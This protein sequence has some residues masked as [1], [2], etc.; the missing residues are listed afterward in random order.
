VNPPSTKQLNAWYCDQPRTGNATCT[1]CGK[2]GPVHYIQPQHPYYADGREGVFR[3]TDCLDKANVEARA[4]RKA[5]L[6]AEPRCEVTGCKRRGNW[7][8]AGALL[9]GRHMKAARAGHYKATASFGILGALMEYDC[10][11]VLTWASAPA[12][13]RPGTDPTFAILTE[14][15]AQ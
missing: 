1:Y 8:S 4:K 2:V 15:V 5:Q 7:R 12:R 10:T 14:E 13:I 11:D 6:A 3:C 9:C